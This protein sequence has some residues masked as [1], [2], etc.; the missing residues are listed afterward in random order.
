MRILLKILMTL[1]GIVAF[2]AMGVGGAVYAY[3]QYGAPLVQDQLNQMEEQ[4]ATSLEEQYPGSDV[5]VDFQEV[6]YKIQGT[7]VFAAFKVNAV[8]TL[9]GVEVD[10]TTNYVTIDV[11][12]AVMGEPVY[13][14]YEESEW[15]QNNEGYKTAPSMIFDGAEAK[16]VG[17][18]IVIISAVAFVG[19]IVVNAVFLRKKRLA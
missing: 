13:E 8:A 18:T 14:T 12:S 4:V 1:V 7:S 3:G 9:G 15:P 2:F 5:T 6:F 17:L 19:S 16:K 11:F 10:N